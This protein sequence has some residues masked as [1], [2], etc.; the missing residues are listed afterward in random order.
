VNKN[1]KLLY[2]IF[3]SISI[4]S[5]IIVGFVV[6][7]YSINF[8]NYKFGLENHGYSYKSKEN[9]LMIVGLNSLLSIASIIFCYF[10][11]YLITLI[12]IALNV[13]LFLI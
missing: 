10:N 3:M 2:Y 9:Y 7:H 1:S 5:L 13:F 4:S 8:D 11:K 6:Y 12:L